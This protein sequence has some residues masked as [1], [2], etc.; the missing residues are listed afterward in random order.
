[1][2]VRDLPLRSDQYLI[3]ADHSSH[4]IRCSEAITKS[5]RA[6]GVGSEKLPRS[7]CQ[8]I[9][10]V[11]VKSVTD[12]LDH[13]D[14]W[15]LNTIG[16]VFF[17]QALTEALN[18][19]SFDLAVEVGAHPALRGPA[20]QVIEGS[21]GRSIPYTGMLSRGSNDV[22]A[23]SDGL[24]YIW[25]NLR[26]SV[27]DF[28]GFSR[29]IEP[30]PL[31]VLK[32]LPPY[33]WNHER[34]FWYESRISRA[35]R[36]RKAHHELLGVKTP[37]Y[38]EDRIAWKHYLGPKELPWLSGHRIQ[39]QLVFPGSGY[40]A[41]AFEAAR[42]ITTRQPIRIIELTNFQFGQALVF[43][44]EDS[45]AEVLISLNSVKRHKST[46]TANFTYHSAVNKDLGA[47]ALN[48]NCQ[49]HIELGSAA[50]V[51]AKYPEQ[52]FGM[53]EVNQEQIYSSLANCGYHYTG[54]FRA[55]H[56][57]Q[58]RSGVATGLIQTP[59]VTAATGLL[60][61]P[62]TID[63]A[64][65]SI[66]VA[67]SYPGDGRMKSVILPVEVAKIAIYPD[68]V[69]NSPNTQQFGF[70]S[71]SREDGSRTEGEV[72]LLS[73]DGAA[74]ILRLEGLRTKPL[75]AATPADDV[76]LFSKSLWGPAF[77][78]VSSIRRSTNGCFTPHQTGV[79]DVV[80]LA[81]QISHRFPSMNI[82]G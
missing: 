2:P 57:V 51:C 55:L 58:R 53:T 32:N 49:L 4:M 71:F 7:D 74:S 24:G 19:S 35:Y 82:L 10:S 36:Y 66:A 34:T 30:S 80:A 61:H 18:R 46:I 73:S 1:M 13:L 42:Q 20:L 16:C 45:F 14:Y 21:L 33:P 68:Q 17:F 44:S 5:L 72:D 26:E 40:I 75:A 62:A 50:E 23:C 39:G 81:Q 70:E 47:M 69:I 60:I 65:H 77:P 76:P 22:Q 64:M 56:S 79:D 6:C 8:W 37:D 27:V 15:H 54:P 9:S 12:D 63:A 29:F 48:A 11:D 28:S 38:S 78:T 3:S 59:E 31:T 52:H 67:S 41:S 43:D 25:A